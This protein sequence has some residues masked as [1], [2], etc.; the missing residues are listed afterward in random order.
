MAEKCTR[1]E[2][3]HLKFHSAWYVEPGGVTPSSGATLF[4]TDA[5]KSFQAWK[6]RNQTCPVGL[7]LLTPLQKCKSLS[8]LSLLDWCTAS[9]LP[10]ASPSIPATIMA[11]FAPSLHSLI[12]MP[13]PAA[14]SQPA[15][16]NKPLH[17]APT[18]ASVFH[19]GGQNQQQC[20]DTFFSPVLSA[21][22]F[23]FWPPVDT[24]WS[25][26]CDVGAFHCFMNK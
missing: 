5:L 4:P 16:K 7:T 11:G 6:E 13:H 15:G 10:G 22:G 25:L 3:S 21:T 18:A 23:F 2:L 17:L 24:Y 12:E 20:T 8:P 14:A 19:K 1:S 9:F 26:V